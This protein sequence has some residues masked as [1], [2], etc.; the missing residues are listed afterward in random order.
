[1]TYSRL[2]LPAGIL[3]AL[4]IQACSTTAVS[5]EQQ[6]TLVEGREQQAAKPTIDAAAMNS[7]Q[8]AL[9]AV[10]QG[11]DDQAVSMLNAM[12]ERYPAFSGPHANLGLI[13]LRQGDHTR[14]EGALQAAT[15]IN[16]KNAVAHNHLGIVYRHQGRFND[17]ESAYLSALQHRPDYANAHLNLAILYDIY[18]QKLDGALQHYQQ[19]QT[20]QGSEDED[21]KK[22]IIGLKRRI[23]VSK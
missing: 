11:N 23:K 13:Y 4:F 22:W 20:L 12:T 16:P 8:Q 5:P 18:L 14:A 7:Y 6:A 3:C 17:A 15:R 2:L 19:F 10:E 21:V 1:M 9:R